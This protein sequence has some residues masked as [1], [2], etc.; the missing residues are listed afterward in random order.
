MHVKYN[1]IDTAL[2]LSLSFWCIF[3]NRSKFTTS[4]ASSC[5]NLAPTFCNT[6][7]ELP[8]TTKAESL[9]LN[10]RLCESSYLIKLAMSSTSL[11]VPSIWSSPM[12]LLSMIAR[13]FSFQTTGHIVS[14]SLTTKV[15]TSGRLV[16]KV[17]SL[18]LARC[19][20]RALRMQIT[21]IEG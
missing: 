5:V 12:V 13:R 8:L 14:R 20:A 17:R 1:H 21:G 3:F 10:A 15:S 16:V 2:L 7:E 18:F 6:L 4:M 11:V 9:W 19:E